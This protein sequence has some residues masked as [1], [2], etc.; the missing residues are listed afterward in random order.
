[1]LHSSYWL[2]QLDHNTELEYKKKVSAVSQQRSIAYQPIMSLKK[3]A[4]F[5]R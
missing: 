3:D 2:R 1:M 4:T 5:D